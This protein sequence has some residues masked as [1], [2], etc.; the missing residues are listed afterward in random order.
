MIREEKLQNV[1]V[2]A[3][4]N[5]YDERFVTLILQ[6]ED[7]ICSVSLYNSKWSIWTKKDEMLKRPLVR[8]DAESVYFATAA[9]SGDKVIRL[10]MQDDGT[11]SEKEVYKLPGS[12]ILM[13]QIDN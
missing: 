6:F 13:L 7:V 9:S 3:K 10:S 12:D 1:E 8:G 2:M 5:D 11:L 4:F